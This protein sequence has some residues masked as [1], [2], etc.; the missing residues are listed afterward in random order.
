MQKREMYEQKIARHHSTRPHVAR[1]YR[2]RRKCEPPGHYRRN[3]SYSNCERPC[4]YRPL[5]N[6]PRSLSKQETGCA[7]PR[8]LQAACIPVHTTDRISTPLDVKDMGLQKQK[9]VGA[10]YT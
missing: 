9:A 4:V 3:N 2:K 8:R 7:A 5:Q 1:L 6:F 10:V